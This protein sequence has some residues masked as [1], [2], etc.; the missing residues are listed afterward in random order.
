MALISYSRGEY[1]RTVSWHRSNSRIDLGDPFP[2]C[3]RDRQMVRSIS[4]KNYFSRTTIET[5]ISHTDNKFHY[6]TNA[7]NLLWIILTLLW[8]CI[9]TAR[10]Q[11]ASHI[12]LFYRIISL[13]R[14]CDSFRIFY[15]IVPQTKN[16]L[17]ICQDL[18]MEES[19]EVFSLVP[20]EIYKNTIS[21]GC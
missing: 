18:L 4:A 11:R 9:R 8:N 2:F 6:T 7:M 13:I 20:N 15:S 5:T 16:S 14:W 21:F 1:S 19:A 10:T 17:I 12:L 3:W